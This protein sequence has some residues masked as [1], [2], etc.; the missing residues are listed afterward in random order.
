MLYLRDDTVRNFEQSRMYWDSM[1]SRPIEADSLPGSPRRSPTASPEKKHPKAQSSPDAPVIDLTGSENFDFG[2]EELKLALLEAQEIRRAMKKSR[3]FSF[4]SEASTANDSVDAG[5]GAPPQAQV[6]RKRFT[7]GEM[8]ERLMAELR[9]Q[10]DLYGFALELAELER[11]RTVQSAQEVVSTVMKQA[12][13]ALTEQNRRQVTIVLYFLN[14]S[15]L[16]GIIYGI[17]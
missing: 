11:S 14:Y 2:E 3:A 4:P 9:R 15:L 13:E 16:Y 5:A 6:P 17:I 7:P 12:E 10:E 1:L 8:K